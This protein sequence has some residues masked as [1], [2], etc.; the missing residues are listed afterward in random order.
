VTTREAGFTATPADD[1]PLTA[2]AATTRA[3]Y[4]STEW[5][6]WGLRRIL[7][8]LTP[9]GGMT[10]ESPAVSLAVANAAGSVAARS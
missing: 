7:D 6:L 5:Y 10:P 3:G 9:R 8:G 1:F 4:V 2:A